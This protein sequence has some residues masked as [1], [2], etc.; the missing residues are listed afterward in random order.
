[1]KK[2]HPSSS[3]QGRVLLPLSWDSWRRGGERKP[4]RSLT[5]GSLLAPSEQGHGSGA[6]PSVSL[7]P[8]PLPLVLL[9]L[10][11]SSPPALHLL[12]LGLSISSSLFSSFTFFLLFFFLLP[13]VYLLFP[14]P[15]PCSVLSANCSSIS[16]L[17]VPQCVLFDS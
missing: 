12:L 4:T 6:H 9:L 11:T 3:S 8:S 2:R 10:C 5:A 13:C 15:S 7:G 1:M 16:L 14:S 17:V